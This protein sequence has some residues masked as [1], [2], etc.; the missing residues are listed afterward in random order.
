MD[1]NAIPIFLEITLLSPFSFELYALS[2]KMCVVTIHNR[3]KICFQT[4]A[5][6]KEYATLKTH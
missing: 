5:T 3:M 4:M 6:Q 2:V 1:S